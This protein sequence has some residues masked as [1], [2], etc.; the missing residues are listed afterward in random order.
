[1]DTVRGMEGASEMEDHFRN[2]FDCVVFH[3]M[4]RFQVDQRTAEEATRIAFQ[5]G[6]VYIE[7]HKGG[8][9]AKGNDTAQGT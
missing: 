2:I 1:V 7:G 4:R 8:A 9:N 6:V 5:A 3:F